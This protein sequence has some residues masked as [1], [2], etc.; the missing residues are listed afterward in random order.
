[1]KKGLLAFLLGLCI[2]FTACNGAGGVNS[3]FDGSSTDF[4]QE[5]SQ[6]GSSSLDDSSSED[7]PNS[8]QNSSSDK[9]SSSVSSSAD[10]NDSSSNSSNS[11]YEDS[12][13]NSSSADKDDSS[14]NSSSADKDDSSSSSSTS[15]SANSSQNS[16][17][18]DSSSDDDTSS[19][20][21]TSSSEDSSGPECGEHVDD[22][23]NGECDECG[24]SVLAVFDFYVIND[25]HGKMVD[26]D[27][28]PGVDELT[29]YLKN[30]REANPNTVFLSSGDTWQGMSESNLTQG[31]ILTEWMNAMG[32]ASMT[33]GNHEYDW[34]EEAVIANAELANFPMLA[35]NV[36]D[37][38]THQL[39]SYCQPSVMVEQNGVKIGI[40]GAIGDCYSSIASDKSAGF[41]FKTGD[42]LTELVKAESRKLR[43]NGAD[44]IIYSIHDGY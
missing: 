2:S 6:L 26:G 12:S 33:L 9:D 44:Y 42:A 31:F 32:F 5:S 43:E 23:D 39:E 1:M 28:Q 18:E 20:S 41:Y 14:S 38:T 29:T 16:S 19:S 21:D 11:S 34:G 13:S 25:I 40:I 3:S 7:R 4:S 35:I 27:S 10:Q 8:S 22:N 17:Y 24:V 15:S 37:S 30:A 36:Y